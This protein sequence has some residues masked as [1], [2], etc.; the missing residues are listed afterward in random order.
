MSTSIQLVTTSDSLA[1]QCFCFV[2]FPGVR[3]SGSAEWPNR[4]A[5]SEREKTNIWI[6][7][8]CGG[9]RNQLPSFSSSHQLPL[10]HKC[11]NV[12]CYR[13]SNC[14]QY[15]VYNHGEVYYLAQPWWSKGISFLHFPA[16]TSYFYS[17]SSIRI[18]MLRV[19][20]FPIASSTLSK[21]CIVFSIFAIPANQ[22]GLRVRQGAFQSGCR[23]A[24]GSG[25]GLD[26]CHGTNEVTQSTEA[27]QTLH[28]ISRRS[29][30]RFGKQKDPFND[31]TASVETP[32]QYKV[33]CILSQ[34][35]NLYPRF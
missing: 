35:S 23:R 8:K 34:K 21:L 32:I 19:T 9:A 28:I 24:C 22:T 25:Q 20:E 6:V 16:H 5:Q 14:K 4:V 17:Y 31:S 33:Q 15:I 1:S 7:A 27:W 10:S 18:Y 26:R 12:A 30:R 3:V 2:C 29:E 13:F 11:Q